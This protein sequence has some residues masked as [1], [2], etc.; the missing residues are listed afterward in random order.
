MIPFKVVNLYLNS[1]W[2]VISLLSII[3]NIESEMFVLNS[4]TCCLRRRLVTP[5]WEKVRLWENLAS[6]WDVAVVILSNL[7]F[8]L[9][10]FFR[11]WQDQV[12]REDAGGIILSSWKLFVWLF[13]LL[14]FIVNFQMIM[15]HNDKSA[16]KKV[17]KLSSK[18]ASGAV[19]S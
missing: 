17:R 12:S 5:G 4:L 15:D 2:F 8:L 3:K 9:R 6:S 19:S 11:F 13:A 18:L 1:N 7:G 14:V 16:W 10:L